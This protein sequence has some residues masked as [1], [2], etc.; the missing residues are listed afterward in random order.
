MWRELAVEAFD[1]KYNDGPSLTYRKVAACGV[2]LGEAVA[3]VS[4]F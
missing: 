3:S 1:Q 2:P 4:V